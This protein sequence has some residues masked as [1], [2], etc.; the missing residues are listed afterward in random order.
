MSLTR[1]FLIRFKSTVPG[2]RA[3]KLLG[4]SET[5][6]GRMLMMKK[7]INAPKNFVDETMDGII[8]AYGDKLHFCN[9]DPRVILSSY[10]CPEGK[11]GIVTGGGSG[12]LPTFLGYVGSGMIDGCVVGNV[13][14][15]PPSSKMAAAIRACDRG[16]GVLC[17][18]GNYGGDKLNFG[19]ACEEVEFDD[20]KTQTV[21]VADDVASSP[22]AT[23]EKR[24]GVAGLVYAYKIAGAAANE[25]RSLDEVAGVTKKALLN[26]R[27]MGVALGPCIVPEAGT[28]SFTINDD[29]IEIGMGIHGEPGIQVRKMMTADEI[30]ETLLIKITDDMPLKTGDEV[31][32]LI[33]GLG[34]TPLEEQ[35]IVFRKVH[36]MLE[37]MGVK[38][39]MPHIGEYATSMEMAGMS[40]TIFRLDDE[41]K[42]LLC[43]PAATPFYTNAN[44]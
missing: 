22:K 17:L 31:S 9:G 10:L 34:A 4:G 28:P 42:K 39:T 24:R 11:V 33:N 43:A 38:V 13:F 40:L 3:R 35:L 37:Q 7:I 12:H 36:M 20:I 44:K 14:A 29:E 21:L 1:C 2:K 8:R 25:M 30:A 18:L 32:V 19:L 15:S 27:S 16:S 5:R 41:L 23:A 6:T 26:I